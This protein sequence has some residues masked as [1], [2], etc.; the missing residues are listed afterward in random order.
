MAAQF[1]YEASFSGSETGPWVPLEVVEDA[2]FIPQGSI[3]GKVTLIMLTLTPVS[4][5]SGYIETTTEPLSRV[6]DDSVQHPVPWSYGTVSAQ[7]Q[8]I[9]WSPTAFRVVCVSGDIHVSVRGI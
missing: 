4:A 9:A 6:I 5:G 7:K 2:Q 3:N 1:E 8:S